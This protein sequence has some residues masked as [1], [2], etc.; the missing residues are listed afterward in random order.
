MASFVE[1]VQSFL[2]PTWAPP[3]AVAKTDTEPNGTFN[4]SLPNELWDRVMQVA[5]HSSVAAMFNVRRA[6][7]QSLTTS[8]LRARVLDVY[9]KQTCPVLPRQALV[10][11]LATVFSGANRL[12]RLTAS[13]PFTLDD[14]RGELYEAWICPNSR[15]VIAE[16]VYPHIVR[17]YDLHQPNKDRLLLPDFKQGLNAVEISFD[18]TRAIIG[19]WGR[20]NEIW[21]FSGATAECMGSIPGELRISSAAFSPDGTAVLVGHVDGAS[22]WDLHQRPFTGVELPGPPSWVYRSAF[23]PDGRRAVTC[24]GD[25]VSRATPSLRL[26]DMTAEVPRLLHSFECSESV[27]AAWFSENGQALLTLS[28][29]TRTAAVWDLQQDPPVALDVSEHAEWVEQRTQGFHRSGSVSTEGGYTI[30]ADSARKAA[31]F[32]RTD[33]A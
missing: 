18:G 13:G 24:S 25:G 15:F 9:K 14:S 16:F 10:E 21:D 32:R 27:G 30:A 5:D 11:R 7:R 12:A 29:E 31:V 20:H 8:Q 33:V 4:I 26:W 23:S 22:L 19:D 1:K 2:P 28:R 3:A 6:F 17:I